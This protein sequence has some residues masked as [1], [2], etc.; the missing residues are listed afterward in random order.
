MIDSFDSIFP[1]QNQD[2][3]FKGPIPHLLSNRVVIQEGDLQGGSFNSFT[4]PENALIQSTPPRT[5]KHLE[6]FRTLG[7]R[8]SEY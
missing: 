2:S 3:E 1:I 7:G 6:K 5:P 4:V 8:K